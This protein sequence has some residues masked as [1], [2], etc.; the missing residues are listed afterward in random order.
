[1]NSES[2]GIN[3]NLLE[4]N[5]LN[6]AVVIG[7]LIYFGGDLFNGLLDARKE[8]ILKSLRDAEEKFARTQNMLKTAEENL[9]SV[10]ELQA[11]AAKERETRLSELRESQLEKGRFA[12]GRLELAQLTT[13]RLEEEKIVSQLYSKT[14]FVALNIAMNKVK[15]QLNSTSKLHRKLINLNIT[16]LNSM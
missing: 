2:F 11:S 6:L 14:T 4:T 13:L 5:V 9:S 15:T 7:C 8:N 10:Q 3:T 12:A 16:L 1:M